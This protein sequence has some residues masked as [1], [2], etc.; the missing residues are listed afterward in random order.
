MMD[1]T[2]IEHVRDHV[3]A[4]L[5]QLEIEIDGYEEEYKRLRLELALRYETM[6]M[7]KNERKYQRKRLEDMLVEDA[8]DSLMGT[9]EQEKRVINDLLDL[10]SKKEPEETQRRDPSLEAESLRIREFQ[11][12]FKKLQEKDENALNTKPADPDGLFGGHGC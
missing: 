4:R 7:L 10:Y 11:K 9:Q 6:R 2:I 5:D 12:A 3:Q 1:R 8:Y